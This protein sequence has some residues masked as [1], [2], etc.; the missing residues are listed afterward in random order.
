MIIKEEQLDGRFSVLN[1]VVYASGSFDLTHI[2]HVLFL[3]DCKKIGDILV[4]GVGNDKN[5]ERYK[6]KPIMNQDIRLNMIDSLKCVD[7]TFIIGDGEES[8]EPS[9]RGLK[10][11]LQL[12]KPTF[13]VINEDALSIDK[14][15]KLIEELGLTGKTK[16]IIMD[17]WCPK[18][19]NNIS[20][21]K[22]IEQIKNGN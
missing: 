11:I 3:E 2:G 9:V 7:Y 5:G 14:R 20:T 19:F 13:W 16:L 8:E 21:T 10:K 1:K 17:R 15:K 6:R 22:L 18:E 4:V 12:L